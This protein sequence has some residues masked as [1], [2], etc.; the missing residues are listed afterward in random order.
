MHMCVCKSYID[1][2]DK[3]NIF[4]ELD[5][6]ETEQSVTWDGNKQQNDGKASAR[7]DIWLYFG[8]M[9]YVQI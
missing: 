4:L 2:F 9:L 5:Y 8:N 3:K 6:Q 1:F 7:G